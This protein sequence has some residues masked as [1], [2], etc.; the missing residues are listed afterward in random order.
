VPRLSL[1]VLVAVLVLVA[2]CG[3]RPVDPPRKPVQLTLSEPQDTATTRDA[4]VRV[5][6]SVSPAG[7]RVLVMGER[8]AVNGG[9]FSTAV[10]LRE[11]ANVIDIGAA[12]PGARATWR[13]LRVTRQSKIELPDLV[14]REA[15][16]ASDAVTALGLSPQV[17]VD[18]DLFDAFRRRPRVVCSTDPV[19]GSQLRPDDEVQLV[20]SK[21]C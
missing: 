7:A 19:A 21:T 1:P 14:G 12:A 11:G 10:D 18:D 17:V 8:V 16:E 6:G 5:S 4:T 3:E 15:D 20:V 9:R 13:A 2:G